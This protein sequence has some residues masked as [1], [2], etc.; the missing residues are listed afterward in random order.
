MDE[1]TLTGT[2]EVELYRLLRFYNREADRCSEA[3]AFLAGCV[4]AGAELETALLLMV[5]IY[6]DEAVTTDKCPRRK[7]SIK[8][9]LDW[10]LGELLRV[11]K[12]AGWLPSALVYGEDEWSNRKAKVGDYAE[13]VRE[14]RNLAHP[15]RYMEDHYRKRVT[16]KHL[17]LVFETIN[18]ASSWLYARIEKSLIERMKS[19]GRTP[20]KKRSYRSHAN[21][22]ARKRVDGK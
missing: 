22:S 19:E 1:L 16:R 4:M 9:L 15:A 13:V 2:Q 7:K 5:N 8:P 6:P 18:S 12:A 20:T 11:A 10:N 21:T 14:M 17:G 3:H